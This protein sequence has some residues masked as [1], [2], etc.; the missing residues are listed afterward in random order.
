MKTSL[1]MVLVLVCICG[2]SIPFVADQEASGTVDI[3]YVLNYTPTSEKNQIG[4]WIEDNDGNYVKS[5][6]V[7][8]HAANG[9]WRER[10]DMLSEWARKSD[11][12][13][14]SSADV[15]AVSRITQAVG[16]QTVVWDLTDKLGAPVSTG[17]YIYKIEGFRSG[18][19][20]VLWR[21][22]ID[23]GGNG[24][25]SVAEAI[26]T[27]SDAAEKGLLLEEVKAAYFNSYVDQGLSQQEW[28]D[29]VSSATVPVTD[30]QKVTLNGVEFLVDSNYQFFTWKEL[31]SDVK[32][33]RMPVK[34]FT[35]SISKNLYR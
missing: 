28:P 24:S 12:K 27:H 34:E 31:P 11:W 5:L 1:S 20:C 2:C 22:R 21:G 33:E 7:T 14:A 10:P 13:N 4:V 26:Y 9:K 29:A 3:T 6:Y 15:D 25:T 30:L 17:I 18:T 32:Y 16:P 23:V 8:P 19:N 35:A